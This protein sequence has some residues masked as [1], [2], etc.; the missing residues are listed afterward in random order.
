MSGHGAR[1][2]RCAQP[3]RVQATSQSRSASFSPLL[4]FRNR[5]DILGVGRS[6][7][8]Q[9]GHDRGIARH[10]RRCVKEMGVKPRDAGRQLRRQ[11]Q[12]LTESADAVAGPV[13]AQVAPPDPQRVLISRQAPR[14]PPGRPDAARL[15]VQIFRQIGYRRRNLVV[16]RVLPGV[17]RMAQREQA[18]IQTQFFE[19]QNFLCDESFGQ[20][21]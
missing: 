5:P 9:P 16:N 20:R 8:G 3:Y 21:G 4:P 17:C 14:P 15:A 11:H 1:S 7:P 2:R 12:G 19:R 13:A 18:Y 10:G 6:T